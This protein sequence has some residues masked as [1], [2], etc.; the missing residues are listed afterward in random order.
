MDTAFKRRWD[1]KYLGINDKDTALVG[2]KVTLG[3]GDYE[4]Q[5]E[6]NE[7]RKQINDFLAEKGINEDKQLGPYFIGKAVVAPED[8]AEIDSDKFC[9]IFKN[10]VIMYLFEDAARQKSKLLFA[11]VLGDQ[12]RYSSICREFDKMGVW[13]FN[14]VITDKLG[15]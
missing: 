4:H 6:W 11:G 9:E 8:G 2:K 1:F 12:T 15:L 10:K 3:K 13:I 5:V 7:L 14:K